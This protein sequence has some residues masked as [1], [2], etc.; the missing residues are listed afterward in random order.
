MQIISR[1]EAAALCRDR[2]AATGFAWH[3]DHMIPLQAKEACG[4]H[5][6]TNLQVIPAM[7]SRRRG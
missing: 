1:K 5:C 2:E 3:V 7:R 6:A 4:L